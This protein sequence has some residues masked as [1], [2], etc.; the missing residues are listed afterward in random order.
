[1]DYIPG[2]S[3]KPDGKCISRVF[4]KFQGK[5]EGQHIVQ[6]GFDLR[7][8][9]I[10]NGTPLLKQSFLGDHSNLVGKHFRFGF[11]TVDFVFFQ[12]DASF[13]ILEFACDGAND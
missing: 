11:Q 10:G 13:E 12:N 3:S 4:R 9:F 8:F 5:L 7:E 1:M 2:M 6:P